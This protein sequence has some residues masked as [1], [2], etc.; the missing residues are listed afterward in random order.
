M[1]RS[2]LSRLEDELPGEL[3]KEYRQSYLKR[4]VRQATISL[5][6]ILL[7]LIAFIGNDLIFYGNSSYFYYLLGGRLAFILFTAGLI[8]FI[9]RTNSSN[10]Y[11]WYVFAWALIGIILMNVLNFTRPEYYIGYSIIDIVIILLI[12]FGIP[13]RIVFWMS[14]AA[15]HSLATVFLIFSTQAG[16][17]LPTIYAILLSLI[18]VNVGGFLI[19]RRMSYYKRSQFL[20][21][22]ELDELAS[23]DSLTGIYNRRIFMELTEKELTRLKRYDKTFTLIVIDLDEFKRINDTYGHLEG[24]AVLK[25]FVEVVDSQIRKSDLFGRVGGEEFC[26]LL[27]ETN[28]SQ[29]MEIV[30]RIQQKCRDA[31]VPTR[32]GQT[33]KFSIST[34]LTEV[35]KTDINLDQIIRRADSALYKAKEGGRDRA[36]YS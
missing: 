13:N 26:I 14:I 27:V 25:K 31:E 2:I 3:E 23:K 15:I 28:L 1:A 33:I 16:T 5:A 30:G 22:Q 21:Y 20:A 32:S 7:P 24:D 9:Q 4:D 12:Y 17:P 6:V 11:D 8:V 36:E 18:L 10:K 35:Q 34:G 19:T 29:G